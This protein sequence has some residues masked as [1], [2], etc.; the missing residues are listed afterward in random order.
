[1]LA[2]SAAENWPS[3]TLLTLYLLSPYASN[4]FD[5]SREIAVPITDDKPQQINKTQTGH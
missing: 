4:A 1:M 2:I 5:F 3:T